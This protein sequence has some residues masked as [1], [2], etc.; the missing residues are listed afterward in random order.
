MSTLEKFL[1]VLTVFF[2]PIR[3]EGSSEVSCSES[4]GRGSSKFCKN[5]SP[6]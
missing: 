2:I 4:G 6:D 1:K 5:A 3:S